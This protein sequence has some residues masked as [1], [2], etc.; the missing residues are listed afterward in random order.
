M[1][2]VTD[3]LFI[4]IPGNSGN[5]RENSLIT[6][7]KLKSTD[8]LKPEHITGF[9]YVK[10]LE[11]IVASLPVSVEKCALV[12]IYRLNSWISI[13]RVIGGETRERIQFN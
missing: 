7:D 6:P 12:S 8:K 11:C 9:R 10:I 1:R 4:Q 3:F 2:G 13:Y 5:S